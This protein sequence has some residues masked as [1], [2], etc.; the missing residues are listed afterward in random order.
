M[1]GAKSRKWVHQK[2]TNKQLMLFYNRLFQGLNFTLHLYANIYLNSYRLFLFQ[3][4]LV[5]YRH[6]PVFKF[7]VMVIGN[8]QI[9][10]SVDTTITE[11]TTWQGKLPKKKWGHTFNKVL[12]YTSSC[13]TYAV[14]LQIENTDTDVPFL[15]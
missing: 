7:T 4:H 1:S 15:F 8:K 14:N 6:E 2:P 10:C 9:S 5:Q 11:V 12:F 3:Q 13:C